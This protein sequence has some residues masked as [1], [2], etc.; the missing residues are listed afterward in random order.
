MSKMSLKV[1][2]GGPEDILDHDHLGLEKSLN[3]VCPKVWER[4]IQYDRTLAL[5][6]DI[7]SEILFSEIKNE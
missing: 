2:E 3:F 7:N 1:R 5:F 6:I 4:W